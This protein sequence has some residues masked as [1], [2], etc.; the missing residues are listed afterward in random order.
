MNSLP[1]KLYFST[2][3]YFHAVL[4]NKKKKKKNRSL[5]LRKLSIFK[6]DAKAP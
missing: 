6:K 2:F 5:F 1:I 4:M 3:T